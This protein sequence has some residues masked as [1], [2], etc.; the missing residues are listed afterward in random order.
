MYAT[1]VEKVLGRIIKK[2]WNGTSK[3]LSTV[4]QKPCTILYVSMNMDMV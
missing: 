4:Y 2:L 3:R 1:N